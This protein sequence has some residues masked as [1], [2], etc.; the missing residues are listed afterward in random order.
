M[1]TISPP[2][3]IPYAGKKMQLQF[4]K[5]PRT[6]WDSYEPWKYG[7]QG[8]PPLECLEETYGSSWQYADS[9]IE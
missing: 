3:D 6:I 5:K 1:K 4:N 2:R 7:V 9:T 8:R